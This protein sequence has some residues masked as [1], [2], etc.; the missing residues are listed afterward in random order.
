MVL[1]DD[2]ILIFILQSG[3][4]GRRTMGRVE[5]GGESLINVYDEYGVL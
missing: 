3:V 5:R 4:S 2:A 1:S